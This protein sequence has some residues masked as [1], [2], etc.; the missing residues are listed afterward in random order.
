[1]NYLDI[2]PKDLSTIIFYY[3]DIIDNLILKDVIKLLYPR[4][5]DFYL[6]NNDNYYFIYKL[7]KKYNKLLN[8]INNNTTI[9]QHYRLLSDLYVT[10]YCLYKENTVIILGDYMLRYPKTDNQKLE[11]IYLM[12]ILFYLTYKIIYLR[13][14]NINTNYNSF[15]LLYPSIIFILIGITDREKSLNQELIEIPEILTKLLEHENTKILSIVL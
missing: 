2:I 5:Y 8:Q 1:M 6:I 13:L 10:P 4:Y 12:D 9:I 3:S 7:I 11:T 14:I 15:N